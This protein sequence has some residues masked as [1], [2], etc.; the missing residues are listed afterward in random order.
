MASIHFPI[1]R[2][3]PVTFHEREKKGQKVPFLSTFFFHYIQ[4][5]Q[6]NQLGFC[7][8]NLTERKKK[9]RE[10]KT[11]VSSFP[12]QS[13]FEYTAEV[14]GHYG[15][16]STDYIFKL[17]CVCRRGDFQ[18]EFSIFFSFCSTK[19]IEN[20]PFFHIYLL[21]LHDCPIFIPTNFFLWLHLK[22]YLAT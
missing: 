21:F 6:L 5:G 20:T 16:G 13:I 8:F 10:K 7:V 11:L 2:S 19:F 4:I 22:M 9:W 17:N 14:I 3:G 1:V 12:S 18:A 15:T